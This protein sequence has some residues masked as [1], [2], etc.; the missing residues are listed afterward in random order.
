MLLLLLANLIILPVAIS[1]F[2]DD[3]SVHW[4][5]FNGVSDTLFHPLSLSL[6]PYLDSCDLDLWP[7]IC[8]SESFLLIHYLIFVVVSPLKDMLRHCVRLSVNLEVHFYF[9]DLDPLNLNFWL[10]LIC[11]TWVV[12]TTTNSDTVFML[13]LV[14]NFRTGMIVFHKNNWVIISKSGMLSF[15]NSKTGNNTNWTAYDVRKKNKTYIT[16]SFIPAVAHLKY[17]LI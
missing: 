2:N 1:F 5:V 16:Q 11:V 8:L 12:N 17:A 3:L 15:E 9:D 6:W 14:I 7:L 10:R 4:I 13:D